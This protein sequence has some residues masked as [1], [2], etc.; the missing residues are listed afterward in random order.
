MLT[1]DYRGGVQKV[2][3]PDDAPI[4]LP[5]PGNSSALQPGE[6]VSFNATHEADGSLHA[7]RVMVGAHGLV[8][9]L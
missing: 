2:L 5:S 6:H 4:V 8:P 9:P 3:V 1:L 7:S